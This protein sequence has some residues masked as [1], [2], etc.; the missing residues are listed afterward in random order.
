MN[1]LEMVSAVLLRPEG[2]SRRRRKSKLLEGELE[3]SREDFAPLA[4]CRGASHSGSPQAR[5]PIGKKRS[6]ARPH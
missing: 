2:E 5:V 3:S 4:L 6:E 1:A